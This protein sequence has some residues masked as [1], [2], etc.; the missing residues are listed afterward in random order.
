MLLKNY[1]HNGWAVETWKNK[2]DKDVVKNHLEKLIAVISY[3]NKIKPSGN[4]FKEITS[5][6]GFNN[7]W[8]NSDVIE[9]FIL[10]KK[11]KNV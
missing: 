5:D 7:K 8:R 10:S 2:N 3:K 11:W 4:L 1:W 6:N 9:K